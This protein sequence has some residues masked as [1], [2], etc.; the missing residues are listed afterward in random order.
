MEHCG[1]STVKKAYSLLRDCLLSSALKP[2]FAAS[3]EI[4]DL[5][6]HFVM[7]NAED[8]EE[9]KDEQYSPDGGYIPRILFI[10]KQINMKYI[11]FNYAVM[12]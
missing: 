4:E 10:G 2:Q 12:L 7:V 1:L 6:S 9:P 8:E 3:K 11:L 5:S